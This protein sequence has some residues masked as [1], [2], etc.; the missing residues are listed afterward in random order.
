MTYYEVLGVL[1]NASPDEIKLA[2]KRAAKRWHPDRHPADSINAT[3]R[4]QE[5]AAAY[6]VL[7]DAAKRA[8]Y[9][10]AAGSG[11]I[12]SQATVDAR[13]A[14]ADTGGP[15]PVCGGLGSVRTPD[16]AKNG[17]ILFWSNKPCPKGCKVKK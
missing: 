10:D 9:D 12:V 15:C 8:E 2:Y 7:G 1:P 4:F 17:R 6:A 16:L 13:A 14:Q 11:G 5:I 3:A